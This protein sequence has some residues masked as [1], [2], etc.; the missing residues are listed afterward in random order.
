[1]NAD[2]ITRYSAPVPRYT[3][4]PTAPHFH[5]GVGETDYITWLGADSHGPLSLYL[6]IPFCDRLCFYC[7]CHTKQVRRYDPI[8]TY[9]KALNSEIAQVATYLTAGRKVTAIHFGGGSPTIVSPADLRTL[10]ATLDDN[11]QIAP[12]CEIS[13]EID[14]THV[15]AERLGAWRDFGITRASVGVQDF[16]PVVQTA[17]NR[18]QSFEQ[19]SEVVEILRDLGVGSINLDIVYGLPHQTREMLLRTIDLSLSMTPDRIAMFGYAHV[20]WVKKHQSLIDTATLAGPIDRFAM[21]RAGAETILGAGYEAIGID[22]FAKP[23]DSMAVKLREGALRRNFQGYTTD[24]AEALIGLG[25]SSI[26]RLPQGYVQNITATGLYC[27]SVSE[28]RLPIARGFALSDAD[29]ATA[30]AIEDLM[31]HY[32]FSI[33]ELRARFGDAADDVCSDALRE[34]FNADGFVTFDGDTFAMTPMG[35]PFVRTIASR[36][37]RYINQGQAKHSAAI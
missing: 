9:L 26:G 33:A 17:I 11:F 25:A 19:T 14:P 15:D 12:G 22:H 37:D 23:D 2:L 31:C 8:A 4:Y 34:S 35:R 29:R 7:G 24:G 6:H 16:A 27:Q 36:F 30:S 28:G 21:A 13:V 5:E 20:P 1:M 3:S 32:A 10:R 18:P